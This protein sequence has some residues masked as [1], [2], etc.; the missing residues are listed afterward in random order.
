M[1]TRA[2]ATLLL[3][4]AA[5]P[6][7]AATEATLPEWLAGHWCGSS[8]DGEVV[9]FWLPPAGGLMLG[10]SRTVGPR[11][12]QFEF[13]RITVVDGKPTYLAQPQGVAPT[14]FDQ[15]ETK[16]QRIDFENPSHDFPQRV[17]YRRNGTQL[18]AEISGPGEGGAPLV[19]GFDYTRCGD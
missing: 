13:L 18:R 14:A 10:M 8:P 1:H 7:I 6:S 3:L 5:S 19:I 12:T 17:A 9:E 11:G 4:G 15:V 16:G 2:I